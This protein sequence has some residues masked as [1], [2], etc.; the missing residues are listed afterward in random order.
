M[1]CPIPILVRRSV[2]PIQRGTEPRAI[3]LF[4]RQP[5]TR[6][7]VYPHVNHYV[8]PRD[9]ETHSVPRAPFRRKFLTGRFRS[10]C[11]ETRLDERIILR[12]QISL[13]TESF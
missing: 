1:G 9:V 13:I 8:R 12:M 3:N 11:E 4:A 6:H 10:L 2:G 7:C 5:A